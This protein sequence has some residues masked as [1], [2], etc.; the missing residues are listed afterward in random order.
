MIGVGWVGLVTAACFAE[1]GH[2]VWAR[3]SRPTRWRRWPAAR[4]QYVV[5]S[6]Q[7]TIDFPDGQTL[8]SAGGTNGFV[9]KPAAGLSLH[10]RL[11]NDLNG[12]EL[13]D[14]GTSG[15][16][17]RTV[18][19]DQNQN[20]LLDMG[21]VSTTT[22]ASGSYVLGNLDPGTPY[23][24]AEVVPVGWSQSTPTSGQSDTY[25]GG[26]VM[27]WSVRRGTL[28]AGQDRRGAANWASSTPTIRRTYARDNLLVGDPSDSVIL[29]ATR[30]R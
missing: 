13:S 30:S 25:V 12:N 18:F 17:G 1:L 27:A 24:I 22:V 10:G 19:L 15:L 28:A 4:C 26:E 3:D 20:G 29:L 9:F 5:G 14:D 21:E 8:T 2:E 23:Y 11:F 6:F 7:G 16:P